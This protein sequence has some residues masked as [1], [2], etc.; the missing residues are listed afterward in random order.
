MP[1][2]EKRVLKIYEMSFAKVASAA[3][4]E[5]TNDQFVKSFTNEAS[6]T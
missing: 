4:V 6:Q 1:H 3:M 5:N 2:T